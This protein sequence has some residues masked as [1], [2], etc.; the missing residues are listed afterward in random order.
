MHSL[1]KC[2][3]GLVLIVCGS[4][5]STRSAFAQFE[6]RGNTISVS[7][8]AQ[9]NVVPDKVLITLGVESVNASLDAAKSANDASCARILAVTQTFKIAAKDVQTDF[10]SI[11][12]RYDPQGRM[13]IIGYTVRK[14][15]LVTLRDIPGFDALLSAAV[16]SYWAFN[17]SHPTFASTAIRPGYWPSRQ[18]KRRPTRWPAPW[19]RTQA[20]R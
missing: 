4:L 5:A 18:P 20:K 3:F 10:I 6:P 14:S 13:T 7:G 1:S 17:S 12:P 2:T 8:D 19:D 15:M 9:V 11:E 16:A